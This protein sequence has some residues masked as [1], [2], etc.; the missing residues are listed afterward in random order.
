[1]TDRPVPSLLDPAAFHAADPLWAVASLLLVAVLAASV[2]EL[3]LRFRRAPS[4]ATSRPNRQLGPERP[5]AGYPRWRAGTRGRPRPGG[6][7][8]FAPHSG[9]LPDNA[10]GIPSRPQEAGSRLG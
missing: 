6:L 8:L 1:M 7:G 2:A 9:G 4:G 3:V 10:R 5:P